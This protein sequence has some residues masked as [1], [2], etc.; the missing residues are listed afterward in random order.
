MNYKPTATLQS[1]LETD[2]Q[3]SGR[4]KERKK[5]QKSKWTAFVAHIILSQNFIERSCILNV[6][7]KN[8][9]VK[10]FVIYWPLGPKRGSPT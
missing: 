4:E 5:E 10:C 7:L 8:D 9:L 3:A 2:K 6:L 1:N